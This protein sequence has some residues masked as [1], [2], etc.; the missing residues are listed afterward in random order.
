MP[1]STQIS[2][3]PRDLDARRETLS[4]ARAL[5]AARRLRDELLYEV[6]FADIEWFIL[7]DLFIA[8]ETGAT[9][10]LSDLYNVIAAPRTTVLR[11]ISRLVEQ[12]LLVRE[13]DRGDGRRKL[14]YLTFEMHAR[15]TFA[16]RRMRD[17]MLGTRAHEV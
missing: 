11:A 8:F 3:E 14:V 10:S 4:F 17:G 16:L 2:I 12:G 13:F 7:I 5:L 15:L 6:E 9:L 1:M